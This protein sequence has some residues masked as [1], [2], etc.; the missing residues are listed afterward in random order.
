MQFLEEAKRWL[1]E[2]T[3]IILLLIALGIAINILLGPEVM[4]FGGIVANLTG[5]IET[6]GES[7]L[8]GLI[9]LGIII[10]LFQRKR[11][12]AYGQGQ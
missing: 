2:I 11:A 1:S 10:V 4:F 3:E 5:L 8:A 7:G 9:G 12:P 6:V